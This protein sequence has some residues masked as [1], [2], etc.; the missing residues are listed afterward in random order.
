MITLKRFRRLEQAVREAGF[1]PSI[2]WS[3][4]IEPPKSATEF[5]SATI[6]VIIHGGMANAVAVHIYARCLAA[7][8]AKGS[9]DRVYGHSGKAAAIDHIWNDREALFQSYQAAEDKLLFLALLP[10]I[11]PVTRLH[12]AK[13]LGADIAKPDVHLERLARAEKTTTAKLC[14]RLALQTGHRVATI[15]TILW[16]ACAEGILKSSVY[17]ADGWR[18]AFRRKV[19]RPTDRLLSS[20]HPSSAR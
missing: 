1:G 2:E 14:R 9:A 5:A 4:R 18:A 10:F 3:E 11:G 7:L 20:E 15:D 12:L 13:N 16:R 6:Y 19:R 8:A 17:E